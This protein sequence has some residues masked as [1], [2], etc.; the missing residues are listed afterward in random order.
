MVLQCH[1][2]LTFDIINGFKNR[3]NVYCYLLLPSQPSQIV[4]Q[5]MW[6]FCIKNCS[7]HRAKFRD[8]INR[9]P[10]PVLPYLFR[11]LFNVVFFMVGTFLRESWCISKIVFSMVFHLQKV[12]SKNSYWIKSYGCF[13]TGYKWRH[14]LPVY[15]VPKGFHE[16]TAV[17]RV[18]MAKIPKQSGQK[19]QSNQRRQKSSLG[20][21]WG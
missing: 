5:K 7:R 10:S 2:N 11:T 13:K 14:L 17:S 16:I 6:A 3:H 15:L 8:E 21:I 12:S 1:R 18:Y 4:P 20:L 9:K 19:R